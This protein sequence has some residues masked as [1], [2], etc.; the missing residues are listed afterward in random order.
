[1]LTVTESVAIE[2]LA[3]TVG[4][5]LGRAL[6]D[7]V[8]ETL[9]IGL[10]VADRLGVLE[11]IALTV[12]IDA[13]VLAVLDSFMEVVPELVGVLEGLGEMLVL[14]LALGEPETL[15]IEADALGEPE[16]NEA[17]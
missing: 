12:R 2:A 3:L 13:D 1:V 8:T 5:L 11:P 7:T 4:D 9:S 6:L 17:D 16:S 10:P 14:G 15:S